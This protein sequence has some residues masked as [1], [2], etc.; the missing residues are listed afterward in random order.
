MPYK[1]DR[2]IANLLLMMVDDPK[3]VMT[4]FH[5][6]AEKDC[7]LGVTVWGNPLEDNFFTLEAKAKES[8]GEK[9]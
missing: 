5:K 2:I 9:E 1:F 6:R 4:N 3:E 7:L 8:S